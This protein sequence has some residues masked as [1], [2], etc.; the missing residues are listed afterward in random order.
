MYEA[1]NA[2]QNQRET[3]DHNGTRGTKIKLNLATCQSP[4]PEITKYYADF[5]A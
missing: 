1:V 2:E 3:S 5:I 4:S